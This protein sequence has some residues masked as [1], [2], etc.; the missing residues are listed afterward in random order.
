M[1]CTYG[2]RAGRHGNP[3]GIRACFSRDDG[4]TWDI[5]NEVVLRRDFFNSDIGYPESMQLPDGRVLTAYYFNT[6]GRY[7]IGGTFWQP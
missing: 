7:Y 2:Y 6:L 1:L 5:N 4:E 3:A